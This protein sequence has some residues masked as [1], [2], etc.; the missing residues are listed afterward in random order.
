MKRKAMT[1]ATEAPRKTGRPRVLSLDDILDA[2]NAIGLTEVSMPAVAA[3]L[4]VG[5]ATLYSYVGGRA[6]L[7]RL[8]SLKKGRQ[9]GVVDVGQDW[10]TLVRDYAKGFFDL[11]SS[12]PQLVIQYM[13]G[14]IGPDVLLDYL[15]SFIGAMERRGFSTSEAFKV[16]TNVNT[17]VMG[18]VV[19][20]A[21]RRF[22]HA[23]GTDLRQTVTAAL[24]ERGADELPR[25]RA[26]AEIL[27]EERTFEFETAL[28]RVI[29]ALASELET[30]TG[31]TRSKRR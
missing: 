17:T 27:D 15:D 19:R 10:R 1:A 26:C 5:A 21:Y 8:A 18:A 6:E 11:W 12:E 24:T 29:E 30:A 3:R 23:Q 14:G 4:G 22:L 25:V 31:A 13:Q 9:T 20:E 7:V 2:A 16:Y 28:E